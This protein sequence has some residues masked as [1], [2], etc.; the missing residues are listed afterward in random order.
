M[1][2]PGKKKTKENRDFKDQGLTYGQKQTG[3]EGETTALRYMDQISFPEICR[4]TQS[5]AYQFLEEAGAVG[6]IAPVCYACGT[7]M[8]PV[9]RNVDADYKCRSSS[10][11]VRSTLSC[12][13]T[14]WTP[15]HASDRQ[16]FEVD[17]KGFLQACY[18]VGVKIPRD[19]CGH[20]LEDVSFNKMSRWLQDIRLACATE[21]YCLSVDTSF[22]DGVVE[23]DTAVTTVD[24]KPS[25]QQVRKA[26]LLFFFPPKYSFGSCCF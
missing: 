24:R 22:E 26:G 9:S 5:Q 1:N 12:P 4:M 11:Y 20:F 25:S 14:A 13:R 8:E 15:L 2:K 3:G 19:A 21:M 16:G 17:W 23:Y 18:L 6:K 7:S 10:C